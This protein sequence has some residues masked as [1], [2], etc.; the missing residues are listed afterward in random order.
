MSSLHVVKY[1]LKN[2]DIKFYFFKKIESRTVGHYLSPEDLKKNEFLDKE[3]ITSDFRGHFNLGD[4]CARTL[5]K[6][7]YYT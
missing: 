2:G 6:R 1:N 5:P 3:K 7:R 4:G